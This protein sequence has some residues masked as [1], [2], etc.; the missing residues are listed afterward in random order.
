MASASDF[1][2]TA[3]HFARLAA[4]TSDDLLME[5]LDMLARAFAEL[6]AAATAPG[7]VADTEHTMGRPT[8]HSEKEIRPYAARRSVEG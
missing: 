4:R 1:S 3:A 7:A 2:A 5:H 6:A 8:P